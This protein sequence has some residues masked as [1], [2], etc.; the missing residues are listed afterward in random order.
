MFSSVLPGFRELRT[1]LA[2][3]YL[4]L[5][6]AWLVIGHDFPTHRPS[7]GVLAEL[8]TL[9]AYAGRAGIFTAISFVAY[10]IGVFVEVDPLKLW[11]YAGRPSWATWIRNKA[12]RRGKI[13]SRI[14]VFPVTSQASN[15]LT[16]YSK[17]DLGREL[18]TDQAFELMRSLLAEEQQIATRLQAANS[19]LYG[20]YDRLLA[21]SAF[22][23]NVA[24]PLTS[25]M[26][27][28]VWSSRLPL[29]WRAA[30][31]LVAV[32]YGALLF[33]QGVVRAMR[34]RDV[35]I[36]ALVIG[37][38]ESRS[39][40]SASLQ[41]ENARLAPGETSPGPNLGLRGQTL[42]RLRRSVRGGLRGRRT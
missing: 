21:E 11:E 9:G 25:F 22:R 23:L 13:L 24:L 12:L 36:Q 41:R 15:D 8:W 6:N 31:T 1:P 19:E 5:V 3:G 34:S 14:Q 32:A 18:D 7:V 33:R 17:D 28:A 26:A 29:H 4:W 37:I 10:M 39:L 42:R 40:K 20:R 16:E 2:I 30:L 27:L 35:I 38:V